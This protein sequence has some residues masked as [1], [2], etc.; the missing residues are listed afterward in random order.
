MFKEEGKLGKLKLIVY[1]YI[2]L[3]INNL[4]QSFNWEYPVFRGQY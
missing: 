4:L 3:Q 2:T 1:Y